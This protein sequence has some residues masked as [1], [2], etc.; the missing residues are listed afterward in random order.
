M[1][2][3]GDAFADRYV[4]SGTRD[5]SPFLAV[6]DAMDF[7]ENLGETALMAYIND[8]SRDGA[9]LM[10]KIWGSAGRGVGGLVAPHAMQAT[11]HNV[12]VPTT[13]N[14]TNQAMQCAKISDQLRNKYRIQICE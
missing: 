5:R 14:A 7:R 11:M 13:G 3:F 1:D 2:S 10:V 12:I 6:G 9:A 4:W 8:L